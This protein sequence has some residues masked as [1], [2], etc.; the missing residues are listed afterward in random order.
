M[1]NGPQDNGHG[2]RKIKRSHIVLAIVVVCVLILL[3][4]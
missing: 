1:S 3:L 4:R 2:K